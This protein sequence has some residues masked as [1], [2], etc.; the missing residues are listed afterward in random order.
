MN[1]L[2]KLS[3]TT[4]F[5]LFVLIPSQ[6]LAATL[7]SDEVVGSSKPEVKNTTSLQN[8]GFTITPNPY[9]SVLGNGTDEFTNWNFDF[10]VSAIKGTVTK[11]LVDLDLTPF[12][13]YETD[14]LLSI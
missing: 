7:I 10:G 9:N 4:V 3:L 14:K 6:A 2:N 13:L 12:S 1:N 11:A 5:F 8:G